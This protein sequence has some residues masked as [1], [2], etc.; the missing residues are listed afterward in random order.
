VSAD[1]VIRVL[2]AA[3]GLGVNIDDEIAAKLEKNRRVIQSADAPA[4]KIGRYPSGYV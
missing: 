1:I 3:P 4:D 2:D